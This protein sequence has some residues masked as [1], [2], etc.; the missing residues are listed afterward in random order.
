[1][2]IDLCNRAPILKPPTYCLVIEI[3][4]LHFCFIKIFLDEIFLND[5]DEKGRMYYVLMYYYVIR[6][7]LL[8]KLILSLQSVDIFNPYHGRAKDIMNDISTG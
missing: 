1:M 6:L 3:E 5:F 7:V 2:V 8:N 4:L